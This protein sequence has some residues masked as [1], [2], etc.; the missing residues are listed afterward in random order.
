MKEGICTAVFTFHNVSINTSTQ[1]SRTASAPRF[2]FHNVSIN[3]LRPGVEDRPLRYLHSTMFLLIQHGPAELHGLHANLHSTMFLLILRS[4]TKWMSASGEF[5]FHN[6]SIN[7]TE[8]AEDRK[9]VANLH[10]TMF[11][12]IPHPSQSLILQA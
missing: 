5:T 9:D 3:T 2:T 7:T 10:S 4:S 12:L 11:L 1:L 6:V 8:R